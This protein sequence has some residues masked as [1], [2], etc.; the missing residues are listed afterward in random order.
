MR[1]AIDTV[2]LS[3]IGSVNRAVF[4]VS[5]GRVVLYRFRGRPVCAP[6]DYRIG[7]SRRRD[8][9]RGLPP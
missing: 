1:Q 8:R 3:V 5:R 4:S 9:T 7:H 6:H 2:L